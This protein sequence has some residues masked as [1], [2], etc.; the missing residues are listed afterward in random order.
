MLRGR[1]W[2][3]LDLRGACRRSRERPPGGICD[4]CSMQCM[5]MAMQYLGLVVISFAGV[6][7]PA[8][9]GDQAENLD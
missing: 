1:I 4:A 6:C 5:Y 9:L 8:Y 7:K 3:Q 2:K